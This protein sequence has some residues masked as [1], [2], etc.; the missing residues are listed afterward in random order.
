[1]TGRGYESGGKRVEDLAPPPMKRELADIRRDID[2]DYRSRLYLLLEEVRR[3]V[4]LYSRDPCDCKYGLRG[5][6]RHGF[7]EQSGCP[8]IRDLIRELTGWSAFNH[9]QSPL[10]DIER[11]REQKNEYHSADTRAVGDG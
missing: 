10:A 3:Q 5:P 6:T 7:G 8:E 9:G 4:C 11:L 2:F 1:M